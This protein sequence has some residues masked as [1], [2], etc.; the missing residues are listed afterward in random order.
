M[1][2]YVHVFSTGL[3][4]FVIFIYKKKIISGV[5]AVLTRCFLH[6]FWISEMQRKVSRMSGKDMDLACNT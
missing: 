5:L 6:R 2:F 1:F 3:I 4:Y